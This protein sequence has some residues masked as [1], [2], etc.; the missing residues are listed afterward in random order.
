MMGGKKKFGTQAFAIRRQTLR[1]PWAAERNR[2]GI[3]MKVCLLSGRTGFVPLIR[4]DVFKT[5]SLKKQE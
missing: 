4:R 3:K 5:P 2:A 1:E